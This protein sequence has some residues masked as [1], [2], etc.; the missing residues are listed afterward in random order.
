MLVNYVSP[1]IVG[2]ALCLLILF[3]TMEIKGEHLRK[4]IKNIAK[5]SF[6]VYLIHVHPL[7]LNSVMVDRFNAFAHMPVWEMTLCI[8]IAVLGIFSVC[9]FIEKIRYHLFEKIGVREFILKRNR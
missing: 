9:I 6:G 8:M 1:T 2:F 4:C 5:L 3:S 7:V